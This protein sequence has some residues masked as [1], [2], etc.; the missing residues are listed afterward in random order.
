MSSRRSKRLPWSSWPAPDLGEELLVT[1]LTL[2]ER[3]E[4]FSELSGGKI[5]GVEANLAG[6][7]KLRTDDDPPTLQAV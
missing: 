2:D 1:G 7:R 5:I 3:M 6:V 4:K